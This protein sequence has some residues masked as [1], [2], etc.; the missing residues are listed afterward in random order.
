M[1]SF[2]KFLVHFTFAKKKKSLCLN[3]VCIKLYEFLKQLTMRRC[4]VNA[5][6]I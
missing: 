3:N 4:I 5:N 1:A 6:T 2:V